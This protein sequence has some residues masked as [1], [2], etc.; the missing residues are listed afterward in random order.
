MKDFELPH[1]RKY[2]QI[3]VTGFRKTSV[4]RLDTLMSFLTSVLFLLLMFYIW[5]AIGRSSDLSRPISDIIAYLAM[6]QVV[7]AVATVNAEEFI[8]ERVR[9]GTIVNELKRPIGL[10]TQV[11]FDQ[12]GVAGF[13]A[14]TRSLPIFLLLFLFIDIQVPSLVRSGAFLVSVVLSI[15]VVFALSYLTAMLVF[16]TKVSWS[17]RMTRY[18]LQNIFSGSMFPLYLLEG[19]LRDLF[20]A[21][22]F[23]TM[24]DSPVSIFLG[25]TALSAVPRTYAIQAVWIL[26]LFVLGE[27]MW[28]KA[29]SFLTVQGG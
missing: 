19:N 2:W 25:E 12:L 24:I 29:K 14:V 8:G 22:P 20:Y 3:F 7:S 26:V 10:Q 15:G 11:L 21:L 1:M 5:T 23:H 28:W 13:R 6:A 27:G 9:K 16:W 18:L 4:Y 17:L